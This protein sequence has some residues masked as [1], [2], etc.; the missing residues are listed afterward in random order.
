MFDLTVSSASKIGIAAPPEYPKIYS[1]PRSSR[2]LIRACA[3]SK[4]CLAIVKIGVSSSMWHYFSN[5]KS[6]IGVK[7]AMRNICAWF[8]L[9]KIAVLGESSEFCRLP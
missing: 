5:S 8:T 7:M 9:L 6:Q 1:T 3:P 2:V 4:F